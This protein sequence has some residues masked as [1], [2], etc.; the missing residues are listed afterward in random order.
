MRQNRMVRS[1]HAHL[2]Q[3]ACTGG[4]DG[5]V[6]NVF[7]FGCSFLRILS[8]G[9]RRNDEEHHGPRR[10]CDYFSY[11]TGTRDMGFG[12]FDEGWR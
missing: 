8:Q 9:I 1:L 7:W 11:P 12:S 5:Q 4:V 2:L 10:I 6:G 3:P